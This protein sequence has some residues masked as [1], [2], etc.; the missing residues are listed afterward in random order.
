MIYKVI[1]LLKDEQLCRTVE[2]QAS[3]VKDIEINLKIK[4]GNDFQEIICVEETFL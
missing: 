1:Y 4:H 2:M 3:D